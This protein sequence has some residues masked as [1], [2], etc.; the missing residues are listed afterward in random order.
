MLILKRNGLAIQTVE[1]GGWFRLPNGDS[2]SPAHIGWEN[3][4]G[5]SIEAE[6][7]P[8]A[9]IPTLDERRAAAKMS[10]KAFCLA[11]K[12]SGLLSP[13]DAASAAKGNLPIAFRDALV[14]AGVD[15]FDAEIIW[16]T[17]EEIWRTDPLIVSLASLPMVGDATADALFGI[18]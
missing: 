8:G 9:V 4:E 16:A 3:D 6:P 11:V 18:N 5:Y 2:V 7:E 13:E 12:A 10:R 17:S 15:G 14:A 1:E